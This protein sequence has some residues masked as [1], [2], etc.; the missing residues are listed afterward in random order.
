MLDVKLYVIGYKMRYVVRILMYVVVVV[1]SLGE[2]RIIW[3][4]FIIHNL[5]VLNA[6]VLVTHIIM[7]PVAKM[8][9]DPMF[10]DLVIGDVVKILGVGGIKDTFVALRVVK[11][12]R[13]MQNVA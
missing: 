3:A 13:I 1:D 9:L 4:Y 8:I 11:H 2:L 5:R 7:L 10:L 12:G 6:V